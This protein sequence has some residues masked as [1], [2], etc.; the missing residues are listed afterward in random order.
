MTSRCMNWESKPSEPSR[1]RGNDAT[2]AARQSRSTVPTNPLKSRRELITVW[3]RQVSARSSIH[4]TA[5]PRTAH[6]LA[7]PTKMMTMRALNRVQSTLTTYLSITIFCNNSRKPTH[8][9]SAT[10]AF[11]SVSMMVYW[12]P[13]HHSSSHIP[14][15]TNIFKSTI[16]SS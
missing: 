1:G 6:P 3:S 12:Q 14:C 7:T 9:S 8:N 2:A 4:K 5:P 13:C 15:F 10:T 11:A 16:S